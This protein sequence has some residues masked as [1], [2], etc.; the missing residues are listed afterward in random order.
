M[1][2][3][4]KLLV[5]VSSLT[6]LATGVI[7]FSNLTSGVLSNSKAIDYSGVEYDGYRKVNKLGTLI[8]D[9]K[10]V[11]VAN[12]SDNK[13]IASS[14][15]Q[16]GDYI[17]GNDVT[18]IINSNGYLPSYSDY[19]T[20]G[21]YNSYRTFETNSKTDS[22]YVGVKSGVSNGL[23]VN[24]TIG[25][26]MYSIDLNEGKA[27]IKRNNENKYLT[28]SNNSLVFYT[29]ASSHNTDMNIYVS[30]D[31]VIESWANKYLMMNSYDKDHLNPNIGNCGK[32]FNNAKEKL[33]SMDD[34]IIS[35]LINNPSF[36]D[37]KDRYLAYAS[38]LNKKPFEI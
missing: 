2:I 35:D 37:V 13:I 11:F 34:F 32:Y 27:V 5:V 6:V 23:F 16:N 36:S 14:N 7:T 4:S 19:Y 28:Y 1:N 25:Y 17:S 30:A 18:S 21:T 10:I 38:A 26:G 8:D 20:L 24:V 31:S 15:T 9:I 33:L 29:D 3:K 12:R 22:R